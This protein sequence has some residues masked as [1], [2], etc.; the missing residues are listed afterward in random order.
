MHDYEKHRI[1]RWEDLVNEAGRS[2]SDKIRRD[3]P[4]EAEKEWADGVKYWRNAA[5]TYKTMFNRAAAKAA[6][7]RA[8]VAEEALRRRIGLGARDESSYY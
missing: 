6:T 5:E 8:N 4:A 3:G 1:D 7:E 2:L